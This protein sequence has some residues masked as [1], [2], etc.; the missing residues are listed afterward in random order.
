MNRLSFNW[1]NGSVVIWRGVDNWQ[2]DD[3]CV[4]YN[5]SQPGKHLIN[6]LFIALPQRHG[7]YNP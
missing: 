2:G 4:S 6:S 1:I 5:P 7:L 3:K